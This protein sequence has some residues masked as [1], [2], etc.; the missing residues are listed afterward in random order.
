MRVVAALATLATLATFSLLSV[1]AGAI[2]AG[3][4]DPAAAG[5]QQDR[6]PARA[7]GPGA[8]AWTLTVDR[9]TPGSDTTLRR[10]A[11][12]EPGAAFDWVQHMSLSVARTPSTE[13]RRDRQVT[14]G[15]RLSF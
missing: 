14:V 9:H 10:V 6:L 15:V 13:G 11:W 8:R 5:P 2:P 4:T 1:P 7:I 3:W 12:S